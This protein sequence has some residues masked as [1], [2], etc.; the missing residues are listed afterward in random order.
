MF[1]QFNTKQFLALSKRFSDTAF[2]A[3]GLAVAGIERAI[4][5][6]LKALESRVN[7]TV[8]FWTEASEIRG[9]EEAR[10]L[11]PKSV[12]LVKDGAEKAYATS[13][14]LLGLT[15]KTAEQIGELVKGQLEATNESFVKP[16]AKKAAK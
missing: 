3:H 7:A 12:E 2:K 9:I 5:V 10:T 15:V 11:L 6:Q 4:D 14:E 1:E 16:A 8:E 13:Q